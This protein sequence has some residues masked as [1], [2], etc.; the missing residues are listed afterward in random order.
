MRVGLC[1]RGNVLEAQSEAL[2]HLSSIG[3]GE[4]QADD[5]LVSGPFTDHLTGAEERSQV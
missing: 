4:V 2:R 1:R 5:L 3:S